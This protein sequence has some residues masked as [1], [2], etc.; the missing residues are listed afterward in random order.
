MSTAP[1][2]PTLDEQIKWVAELAAFSRRQQATFLETGRTELAAEA[3]RNW[4]LSEAVV[5][6]LMAGRKDITSLIE[7][8]AAAGKLR[9]PTAVVRI[10][11]GAAYEN[12]AILNAD[13]LA[14]PYWLDAFLKQFSQR[15]AAVIRQGL[16]EHPTSR[17]EAP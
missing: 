5:L 11:C 14:S 15:L 12:M 3:G 17:R 6:S 2:P 4:A 10:S 1:V 8:D 13:L 9:S 16:G 7:A